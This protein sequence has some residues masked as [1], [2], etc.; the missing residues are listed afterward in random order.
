MLKAFTLL[1]FWNLLVWML[2]TWSSKIC[3]VSVL[4]YAVFSMREFTLVSFTL[5]QTTQLTPDI[6][7]FFYMLTIHAVFQRQWSGYILFQMMQL[8]PCP[9]C[10]SQ[11]CLNEAKRHR[12]SVEYRAALP[13]TGWAANRPPVR[14][15]ITVYNEQF[16]WGIITMF[17]FKENYWFIKVWIQHCVIMMRSLWV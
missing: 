9:P 1:F 10:C 3:C 11:A 13:S 6:H 7:L 12:H 15:L 4:V 8:Q 14:K 5:L 16:S 2:K 17:H